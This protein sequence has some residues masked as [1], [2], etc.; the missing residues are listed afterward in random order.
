MQFN[1]LYVY[2][3][4]LLFI[5][6]VI[7]CNSHYVELRYIV[8]QGRYYVTLN[9][10]KTKLQ[11]PV[12]MALPFS[13]TTEYHYSTFLPNGFNLTVEL[14]NNNY[15]AVEINEIINIINPT[16]NTN[17]DNDSMCVIK[18]FKFYLFEKTDIYLKHNDGLAFP[19]KHRDTSY[20]LISLLYNQ[21]LI[22]HKS[23]AFTPHSKYQGVLYFGNISLPS[24]T[25]NNIITIH[26]DTT[27]PY[28]GNNHLHKVTLMYNHSLYTYNIPSNSNNNSYFYFQTA[29]E[30]I[31]IPRIFWN[32]FLS[33]LNTPISLRDCWLNDVNRETIIM[34]L[35][36]VID[37]FNSIS[38]YIEP[39]T[40]N[41]NNIELTIQFTTLFTCL[42]GVCQCVLR[43]SSEINPNNNWIFGTSFLSNF[44]SIFDY[45]RHAIT[46]QSLSNYY[47]INYTY[48]SYNNNIMII[49]IKYN[50]VLMCIMCVLLLLIKYLNNK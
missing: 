1:L 37:T 12:D 16:T 50:S 23:F 18:G 8:M 4:S 42:H 10:T 22:K 34:C 9:L 49:L 2:Y 14:N 26:V 40:N 19:Y 7:G 17:N 25:S 30:H 5:V 24:S 48:T 13:F 29:K 32:Y 27:Q 43:F 45:E 21:Q 38:F 35:D 3:W 15:S 11:V 39:T 6:C 47:T 36:S 41:N 31:Y 33:I 20:S 46:L 28:W 44:N